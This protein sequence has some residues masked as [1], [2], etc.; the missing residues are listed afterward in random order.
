MFS[1][2]VLLSLFLFVFVGSLS[3]VPGCSEAENTVL[4][5]SPKEKRAAD[6]A[7]GMASASG[8]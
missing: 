6:E 8:L 1:K 7:K 5:P 2:K 3:V 4:E